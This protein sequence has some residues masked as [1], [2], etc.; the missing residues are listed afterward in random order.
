MAPQA[1]LIVFSHLAWNFVYQRPQHLLSRLAQHYRV[2]FI[3]EP[4]HAEQPH[5]QYRAGGDNI[6]V[7]Q[8]QTPCQTRGYSDEQLQ[9]IGPMLAELKQQ[10]HVGQHLAWFYT[11]LA[12]PLLE[13]L[14]AELVVYDCMDA[15]DMF[16]HA[17]QQLKD[18]E[19]ELLERADLVFTGGPSLYRRLQNRHT[20]VHCFASSVDAAHYAAANASQRAEPIDQ[21]VIPRPRL[22]YFGVI[23]ERID[24]PLIDGLA[25]ERPEWQI[26]MVGPVAKIDVAHLPRRANIHYLGQKQYDELP[27]YLDGWDVCLLPFARNDSTRFISPTKTLEYM[28][29][30][31]P[32]VSTP[33]T[34]VAEPYGD[35]VYLADDVPSIVAA[36]DAALNQADDE[37]QQRLQKMRE[38]LAHTSWNET[39][40]KMQELIQR[41]LKRQKQA[42]EHVVVRRRSDPPVVVIGAGPTG[43]S[44]AYHLGNDALLLEQNS[45]VGGWCRSMDVGGF[46]F[47]YAGHIMFSNEP[48]VHELYDMLL[49]DNVHWQDR[50]AWIYSKS[51][52][53]RYP[54]QG[55]L[56][57]LPPDVIKECLVGAIEARFGALK[58]HAKHLAGTNG[59]TNG[60]GTNGNGAATNG[61]APS[62]RDIE[63]TAKK[64]GSSCHAGDVKDCCGDGVMESTAA[65]GVAKGPHAAN[66]EDFIYQVWGA[67]IAKHFAI[68]YNRKLWAVPLKEMETSWL[69]GR[70]PMPDLEE[71]IEGALQPTAKP[72]GPNARFGYPLRGGFQSLMDG[73]L[74]Y[75]RHQLRLNA[76]VA[77]VSPGEHTLTLTDGTVV[78]YEQLIST[79]PLPTL[80]RLMGDEVPQEVRD[81]ARGLRHVSVRCVH[82][83]I[84]REN[85]TEKHW[86]YYPE[87]TVFHRIFVQGNAS[88][89]C[90]P[91]GGFGLTCEITYS[92]YKP[93]P[94]DGEAL[95]ERCIEDCRQVGI[96]SDSDPVWATAQVDL[97]YAYVVYDHARPQNVATIRKWMESHAVVLAGRY[98]EWEYYNSDHAFIAGKNA[99]E[100]VMGMSSSRRTGLLPAKLGK[101]AS[102]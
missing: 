75:V 42:A 41:E 94:C 79:M 100:A 69:G 47:D 81:A 31:K 37:A 92:A 54:F 45:R 12:L 5:W 22:G 72:M 36:C 78:P 52:Y 20:N 67:G 53:T 3:E 55:A 26:V 8:A 90:N 1:D 56:Y 63:S 97:P 32:I 17:P 23:D 14:D 98:S 4:G 25:S 35:I 61:H 96:I 80:V 93:L 87:Q 24:L 29:A 9:F 91:P 10:Q 64:D 86:I 28:A 76:K 46:T 59:H 18:R 101:T 84:G 48:Y 71:L 57:G 65:L 83:G 34:D 60:N 62:L 58:S 11:P 21:Q 85:L 43:L 13:H 82:L 74:P 99:A 39:V 30:E 50:E 88:P 77:K 49:G 44:A 89:H 19:A 16:L 51:V 73:F 68:P 102:S 40:A 7:A 2:I 70:V 66:F 6:I 95:I 38:V 15:L 27:A 33:I